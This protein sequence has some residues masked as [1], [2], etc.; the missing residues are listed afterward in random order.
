MY[1]APEDVD[2]HSILDW[3][4]THWARWKQAVEFDGFVPPV[5]MHDYSLAPYRPQKPDPELCAKKQ[6][7]S[8]DQG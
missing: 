8:A 3:E 6:A 7:T 4:S 2:G 1:S 5:A